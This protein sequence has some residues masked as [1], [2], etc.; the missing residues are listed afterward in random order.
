MSSCG[1]GDLAHKPLPCDFNHV[2]GPFDIIGDVHGCADELEMLLCRLGYQSTSPRIWSPHA[3][4]HPEGRMAVFVGDLVDRGPRVLDSLGIVHNMCVL[5]SGMCVSGNHDAKLLRKLQGRNV[6]IG[7]GLA[8]TL[9]EIEAL[10]GESRQSI[11]EHIA[12]FLTE[13]PS[14]LV[15]DQGRLVVAHA[16]LKEE[17]HGRESPQILAFAL[18]GDT[19]GEVDK[20]GLPIRRD[21]AAEYRGQSKVVYGHTPVPAPVWVNGTVDIDTGCVFG[22]MLTALRYPELEFVSVPAAKVYCEPPRP[23]LPQKM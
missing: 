22:G 4:H 9:S 6:K 21:W 13:L 10:P 1:E 7:H 19:T 23:F 14:H 8:M 5:G 16:G 11:T 20:D 18:Y 2:Q 12:G 3:Y 15:L 17:F